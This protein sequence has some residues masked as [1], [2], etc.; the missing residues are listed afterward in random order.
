MSALSLF[1]TELF[2]ENGTKRV[3]IRVDNVKKTHSSS[4]RRTK[5]L[6]AVLSRS[7][8]PRDR[9][10]GMTNIIPNEVFS[11]SNTQR[12]GSVDSLLS[13]PRRQKSRST[14]RR[15]SVDSLLSLP[16]R[17]RSRNT[18]ICGSVDSLLALPRRK[19]SNE[20]LQWNVK[21]DTARK[22]AAELLFFDNF[23]LDK[24]ETKTTRIKTKTTTMAIFA[25]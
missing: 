2:E 15:G 24:K 14:E 23:R 20:N 21:G 18:E 22:E 12:R 19:R 9:W 16:P 7:D 1:L 13:L 11:L 25:D 5:T 6:E 17:Q 8:H 3:H 4:Q 10:S